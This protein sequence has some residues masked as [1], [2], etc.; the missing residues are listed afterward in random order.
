MVQG[1]SLLGAYPGGSNK[2]RRQWLILGATWKC[3]TGCPDTLLTPTFMPADTHIYS[4][5]N[6]CIFMCYGHLPIAVYSAHLWGHSLIYVYVHIYA[7]VY[8]HLGAYG[9]IYMTIAVPP[10]R[11]LIHLWGAMRINMSES[12]HYGY[13]Q[14]VIGAIGPSLML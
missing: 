1:Y 9:D 14:E 4:D 7:Y 12:F 5:I 6:T 3:S 2:W 8:I 11:V 10:P 13:S